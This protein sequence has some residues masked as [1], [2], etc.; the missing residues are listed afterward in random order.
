MP[1][2]PGTPSTAG[3]CCL[4][5]PAGPGHSKL[6]PALVS[7]V[8]HLQQAYR[9]QERHDLTVRLISS[10][11]SQTAHFS[12]ARLTPR[13]V[14]AHTVRAAP[15]TTFDEHPP[16][17][18]TSSCACAGGAWHAWHCTSSHVSCGG[19]R[20]GSIATVSSAARTFDCH[21]PRLSTPLRARHD[22]GRVA[23]SFVEVPGACL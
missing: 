7:A 5:A 16:P 3:N 2:R 22:R 17:S 21:A 12:A 6:R 23:V 4:C 19:P 14:I 10:V 20:H 15:G 9:P 11:S 1:T 18:S 13:F 8:K